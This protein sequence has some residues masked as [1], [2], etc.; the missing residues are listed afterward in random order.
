M[1]PEVEAL[2]AQNAS[3]HQ[4]LEVKT[5]RIVEL[6]AALEAAQRATSFIAALA[7]AAPL[8]AR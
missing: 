7:R 5:K 3:L 4:Q 8:Q 1:A 2:R 6:Q